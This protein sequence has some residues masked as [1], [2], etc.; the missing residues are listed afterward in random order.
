[1]GYMDGASDGQKAVFQS[2]F[3]L[4]YK[5]GLNFGFDLGLRKVMR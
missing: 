2:S 3:N 1:M 4:G 5:Q